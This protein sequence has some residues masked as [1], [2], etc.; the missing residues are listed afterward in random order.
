MRLFHFVDMWHL[1]HK[2]KSEQG[3]KFTF[4]LK[5]Q[6]IDLYIFE[7]IKKYLHF[8][9]KFSIFFALLRIE[10]VNVTGE[11]MI[12][13]HK[14]RDYLKY[15]TVE[16]RL[17]SSNQSRFMQAQVRRIQVDKWCEGIRIQQDPGQDYVIQWI[18]QYAQQFRHAWN[19]SLCQQCKKVSICGHLVLRQCESFDLVG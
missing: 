19:H 12:T 10:E 11:I 5:L 16:D 1:G 9:V 18:S 15:S 17:D 4:Y 7:P 2:R 6:V 3:I 8:S 13:N 14:K